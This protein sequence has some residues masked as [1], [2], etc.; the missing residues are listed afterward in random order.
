M[1]Y[2]I[3]NLVHMILLPV[4]QEILAGYSPTNPILWGCLFVSTV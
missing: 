3:C 1:N 2:E 4:L